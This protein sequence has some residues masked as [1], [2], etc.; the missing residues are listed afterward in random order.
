ML[1][2]DSKKILNYDS[3]LLFI[4]RSLFLFPPV[5]ARNFLDFLLTMKQRIVL[6][7]FTK[8]SAVN[9]M[10]FFFIWIIVSLSHSFP[11]VLLSFNRD[12]RLEKPINN[13]STSSER[14]ILTIKFVQNWLELTMLRFVVINFT[15][16]TLAHIYRMWLIPSQSIEYH[17]RIIRLSY[18][19]WIH[20]LLLKM[21][22]K[23]HFMTATSVNCKCVSL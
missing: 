2:N 8:H 11:I 9:E 1:S 18:V 3:G 23:F 12:K 21:A 14:A 5:R 15:V 7:F 22:V 13:R 4:T 6:A 19:L 17:L 10:V 16:C 20:L